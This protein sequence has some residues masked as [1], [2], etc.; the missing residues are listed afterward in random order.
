[1]RDSVFGRNNCNIVY[2]PVEARVNARLIHCEY[3]E[4][5]NGKVNTN[6]SVWKKQLRL[7]STTVACVT[8][9]S[10]MRE[11]TCGDQVFAGVGDAL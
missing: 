6:L 1:M 2:V 11:M 4:N 3:K 8:H 9:A 7:P 10:R 5:T